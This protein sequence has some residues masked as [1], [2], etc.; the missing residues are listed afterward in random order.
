[1]KVRSLSLTT[2]TKYLR[3]AIKSHGYGTCWN[4]GNEKTWHCPNLTLRGSC[5]GATVIELHAVY[6]KRE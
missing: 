4:S 6:T 2:L 3:Q 5:A 1:M